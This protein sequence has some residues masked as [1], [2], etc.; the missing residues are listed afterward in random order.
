MKKPA[1]TQA[2][3]KEL[4]D[5]REDGAMVRKVRTSNH[6]A[7]VGDIAG[8]LDAKGYLITRVGGRQMKV[9]RLVWLWHRGYL[10]EGGLDHRDQNKIN[11]RIDN[12]R[13]LGR[14][15]NARN[16]KQRVS[17]SGVKGV[18]WN[19]KEKRWLA[20][21]CLGNGVVRVGSCGDIIEAACHR[22]A[23]EQC[24]GWEDCD[25]TSP[26]FLVVQKYLQRNK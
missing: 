9:H 4:F 25:A 20:R 6:G 7:M 26:A 15:C 3:V 17:A 11:N 8:S 21:I 10:P 5:Y 2:R 1:L 12:L 23:A 14:Q 22:L 19:A 18:R 13:E 24:V 16:C